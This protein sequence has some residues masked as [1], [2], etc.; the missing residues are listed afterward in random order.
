[1]YAQP[2]MWFYEWVVREQ[3]FNTQQGF[4]ENCVCYCNKN[5]SLKRHFSCFIGLK[6]NLT[7]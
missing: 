6:K 5:I 3:I 4:W 2:I 7:E 1:M